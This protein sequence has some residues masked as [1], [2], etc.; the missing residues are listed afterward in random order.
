[1]PADKFVAGFIGTPPMN[2]LEGQVRRANGIVQVYIGDYA[3]TP[4][5]EMAEI[6]ARYDGQLIV[7]GI[8]A[9]N[10][11]ALAQPAVDALKVRVL[12]VEPLGSQNL[13]TIRI[14]ED[15]IKVS[16]HPDFRIAPD[17]DIWVRFPSD[18]IRWIDR[19]SG[20]TLIPDLEKL[21]S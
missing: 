4:V 15:I 21:V 12:V 9:E 3:L 20:K 11:E 8:R 7:V 5:S 6:L 14:G 16:T 13:L 17:Q 10:M 2:F 19:E 1:M 18:K